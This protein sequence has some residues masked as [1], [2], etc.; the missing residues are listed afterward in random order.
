MKGFR[1]VAD[2]SC[3]IG[4]SQVDLFELLRELFLEVYIPE[5]V[6]EE[7]VAEGRGEAGS[8]ETESAVRGGWLSTRAV[9]DEMAVNA[10]KTTLGRG[11]SEVIILCKE[12][13][14]DYA[15]MDERT[16]RFRAE[17][18]HVKTIGVLGLLDLAIEMGFSIDKHYIVKRLRKAGFRISDRLYGKMFPDFK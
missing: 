7:V 8:A 14:A 3:L 13:G 1:V 5:A 4:L 17:L 15:L 11:E 2:S 18:M 16:A 10:L 6:Y 9:K 12:L